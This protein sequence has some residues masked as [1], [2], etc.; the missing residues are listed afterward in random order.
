MTALAF[1]RKKKMFEMNTGFTS[2]PA[3][4]R[5]RPAGKPPARGRQRLCALALCA[6]WTLAGGTAGVQAAPAP[7]HVQAQEQ[8]QLPAA[9]DYY[10]M[11]D[12]QIAANY[13]TGAIDNLDLAIARESD[14]AEAYALRAVAYN[15]I[16]A[17]QQADD[18]IRQA[19]ALAPE[20]PLVL[21]ARAALALDRAQY[22][23]AADDAY[24][25]TQLAPDF[26]YAHGIYTTALIKLNR[27]P[28]ALAHLESIIAATPA[29]PL[30]YGLLFN[31][32]N[33][34]G[35]QDKMMDTLNRAVAAAPNTAIYMYRARL[36]A[37]TDR[38][39]RASDYAAAVRLAEI[40]LD[41]L[42]DQ[43]IWELD[44]GR[45]DDAVTAFGAAIASA[46][47]A[48]KVTMLKALRAVAYSRIGKPQLAAADLANVRAGLTDADQMNSVAWMLA[49]RNTALPVALSLA[50]AAL[51]LDA[52]SA[53][54]L[55]TSGV[56]LLQLGR[57]TEAVRQLDVALGIEPRMAGT[58]YVRG[59]ARRRLGQT[60]AGDADLGAARAI[61]PAIDAEYARYGIT[62]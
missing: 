44:A 45:D 46:G 10:Q 21:G 27:Q 13:Y 53:P 36:R 6:L 9:I 15:R 28:E 56:I 37:P 4:A 5:P 19:V 33:N 7:A 14:F 17:P 42:R 29:D 2:H 55:D 40:P 30:A 54:F 3:P 51:A 52:H 61:N 11:A 31:L 57:H 39:G 50:D 43:A 47:E 34:G 38:A 60:A 32:Y 16:N 18:D 62:P 24:R 1:I 26:H 25:A 59:V 22:A 12:R 58:L 23:A 35:D 49:T 8:G 48:D 20:S 41:V